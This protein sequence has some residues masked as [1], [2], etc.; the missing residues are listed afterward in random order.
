MSWLCIFL[1]HKWIHVIDVCAIGLWQ[2]TR[3]KEISIGQ[4]KLS[5]Q[6]ALEAK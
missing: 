2:C 1:P 4:T 6:K 5:Y 3:C